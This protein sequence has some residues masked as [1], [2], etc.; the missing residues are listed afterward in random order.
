MSNVNNFRHGIVL[1]ILAESRG[2]EYSIIFL[3]REKQSNSEAMEK[4]GL[5]RKG[6]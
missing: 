4:I 5:G 2:E 1:F 6:C 3:S